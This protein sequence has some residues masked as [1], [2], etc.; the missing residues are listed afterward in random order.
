MTIAHMCLLTSTIRTYI[1]EKGDM[2][3]FCVQKTDKELDHFFRTM[4]EC[5]VKGEGSIGKVFKCKKVDGSVIAVKV[6]SVKSI[7]KQDYSKEIQHIVDEIKMMRVL[8]STLENMIF[9][10]YA[11]IS[12][13]DSCFY[14]ASTVYLVMRYFE[15]S[16]DEFI[17]DKINASNNLSLMKNIFM[18]MGIVKALYRMHKE[19]FLHLDI[20]PANIL[21]RDNYIPILADYTLTKKY[22]KTRSM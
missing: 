9:N 16:L 7:N 15:N 6:M 22:L 12:E 3:S 10:S 17:E 21:I 1:V 20:K 19:G 18:S 14:F 2:P 5:N 13:T 4:S 11:G 8:D